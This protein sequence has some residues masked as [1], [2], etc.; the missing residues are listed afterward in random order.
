MRNLVDVGLIPVWLE[1][2]AYAWRSVDVVDVDEEDLVAAAEAVTS[3]AELL[4][5][6]GG[7][8]VEIELPT[9]SAP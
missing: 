1:P 4:S 8:E 6:G 7:V 2:M 5:S 3:L 9:L